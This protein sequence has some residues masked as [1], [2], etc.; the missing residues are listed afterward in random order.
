MIL[1]LASKSQ[2]RQ[3]LLRDAHIPF[4]VIEHNSDE[5]IDPAGKTLKELVIAIAE[6]K[7]KTVEMTGTMESPSFILTCDS[8]VQTHKCKT[9]LGKPRDMEHAREILKIVGQGPI[10]VESG[11]CLEKRVF[12]GTA[13]VTE[14]KMSW[15]TGAVVEMIPDESVIEEYFTAT[16]GALH[17]CGAST[18]EGFGTRFLK[19]TNGSYTAII[20]LPI[21]ELCEALR[22]IG[23]K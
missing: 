3:Q 4:E 11:C 23:F 18:I 13:W 8:L 5:N 12:D 15:A 9:F 19:S 10:D 20:G 17:A 14:K 16:P 1:S 21:F 7:M 22:E 6:D 2:S